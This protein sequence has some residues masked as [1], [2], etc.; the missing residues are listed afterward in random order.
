MMGLI[1]CAEN[2]KEKGTAQKVRQHLTRPDHKRTL[3]RRCADGC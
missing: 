2:G 3:S 1:G